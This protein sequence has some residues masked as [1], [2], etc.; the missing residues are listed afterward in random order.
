MVVRKIPFRI[1]LILLGT[2]ASSV[3]FVVLV[4]LKS[5]SITIESEKFA[6][7]QMRLLPHLRITEL[8]SNS[9]KTTLLE[10]LVSASPMAERTYVQILDKNGNVKVSA[11]SVP[12]SADSDAIG[13]L[14]PL[15]GDSVEFAELRFGIDS[16]FM[17]V[18]RQVSGETF[19]YT[20]PAVVFFI[21]YSIILIRSQLPVVDGFK[22]M[23]KAFQII[24]HNSSLRARK[25]GI[26]ENNHN[27]KLLII[28]LYKHVKTLREDCAMLNTSTK[29]LAYQKTNSE[30]ILRSAPQGVLVLDETGQVS[31]A[32]QQF[33]R[34]YRLDAEQVLG[35]SPSDW[36]ERSEMKTFLNQYRG[37]VVRRAESGTVEFDPPGKPDAYLSM[38][39]YPMFSSKTEEHIK[40]TLVVFSDTTSEI[41]A[42][43]AREDFA[44]SAAHELKT[45]LHAIGMHAEMLL[46]EDGE[47][48]SLRVE[49]ANFINTEVAHIGELVRNMLS[50]TRIEIGNLSINR[51]LTK[52]DSLLDT[53]ISSMETNASEH[54]ITLVKDY[55]KGMEPSFLDKDLLRVAL[56]NLLSNAIKY[57]KPG[58]E[59]KISVTEAEYSL[60]LTVSDTG[61]GI[62]EDEKLRIFEKFF[63]SEDTRIREISGHGLGLSLVKEI[64]ELHGGTI[65]VES[66]VGK[67]TDF[68]V[69]L[70]KINVPLKEA[71]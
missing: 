51:K 61:L 17:S 66:T 4:V 59:V 45:P 42:E 52:L 28:S 38:T 33:L 56:S 5:S 15:Q 25:P 43:K 18:L 53:L 26:A 60:M 54:N 16:G 8:N 62:N 64:I 58:G 7:A 69:R 50:I 55:Q 27:L 21:L 46:T 14:I 63:R 68:I 44:V 24:P 65:S 71:A 35:K 48:K 40:S 22:L 31:F 2:L 37:S 23:N 30:S 20:L 47:D 41:Q 36:C 12:S 34:W 1:Q 19:L 13:F 29:V 67:G 49:S 57:N 3:V 70:K 32:N 6:Q 9:L 11:G 39:A 10:S